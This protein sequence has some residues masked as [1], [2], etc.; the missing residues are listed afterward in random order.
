MIKRILNWI[1]TMAQRKVAQLKEFF[2]R[3]AYPKE[4]DFADLLE[5]YVH[6]DDEIEIAKVKNLSATL[7]TK[8]DKISA[9]TLIQKQTN[10]AKDIEEIKNRVSTL[11][12][13]A[14]IVASS[15]NVMVDVATDENKGKMVYLATAGVDVYVFTHLDGEAFGRCYALASAVESGDDFALYADSSIQ[16]PF[17][18]DEGQLGFGYFDENGTV[19][20][21]FGSSANAMM[22]GYD[23]DGNITYEKGLY[24]VIGAGRIEPI[25]TEAD[26]DR[27]NAGVGK[28]VDLTPYAKKSML[29]QLG[30]LVSAK[31]DKA[32]EMMNLAKK[33][34]IGKLIYLTET[35]IDVYVFTNPDG[36]A[37]GRCYASADE[38]ESGDDFALYADI[39][40]QNPFVNYDG[41]IATG[42]FDESGVFYL[43]YESKNNTTYYIYN[44]DDNI[45][46]EKG[47]YVVTGDYTVEPVIAGIDSGTICKVNGISP[48]K[49]E[50]RLTASDILAKGEAFDLVK[51]ENY[52][53]ETDLNSFVAVM[54]EYIGYLVFAIDIF[55]QSVNGDFVLEIEP[56]EGVHTGAYTTEEFEELRNA[57]NSGMS[58][59]IRSNA[60]Q[61]TAVSETDNDYVILRYSIPRIN[62]DNSTITMSFYELKYSAT[63]YTTKVIHKTIA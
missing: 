43:Y 25:I 17:K 36:E 9:L 51:Q 44:P 57:I 56:K 50:V 31:V 59:I 41:E 14:S 39:E 1:R 7:S 58:I 13:I 53:Y 46:Y 49:G 29:D 24:V 60:T 16:T 54:Y 38:V 19:Y 23:P 40:L 48:T 27:W 18:N 34:S 42:Y 6:K 52:E 32:S 21:Y 45:T 20:V 33:T 61:V 28:E 15:P 62:E 22:Y 11:E 10:Q 35:S 37:Y 26:F 2:K 3:G 63:E 5:S 4:S 55:S 30:N 47:L 12:G 8:Y